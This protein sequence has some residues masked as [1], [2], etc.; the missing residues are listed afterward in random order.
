MFLLTT[1]YASNEECML[2]LAKEL[3]PDHVKERGELGTLG[4][5]LKRIPINEVPFFAEQVNS[6]M[7]SHLQTNF[8]LLVSEL[9]QVSD[10]N[11]RLQLFKELMALIHDQPNDDVSY[12]LIELRLVSKVDRLHFVDQ[13]LQL[14]HTLTHPLEKED[15]GTIMWLLRE[16]HSSI[17]RQDIVNR[18]L[19]QVHQ[20]SK[21]M[22]YGCNDLLKMLETKGELGYFM[23]K[24]EH[25][26]KQSSPH[27][28]PK[29]RTSF[30]NLNM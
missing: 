8:N 10:H 4:C 22:H 15:L 9:S 20:H 12:T 17:E 21:D 5:Y 19:A 11:E 2:A 25:M 24:K 16:V 30:H 23:K 28:S 26:H 29:K 27:S 14:I 3:F 1:L 7:K 18:I 13:V 6:L